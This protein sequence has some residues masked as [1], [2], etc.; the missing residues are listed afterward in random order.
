MNKNLG[1]LKL[2]LCSQDTHGS[3]EAPRDFASSTPAST[4]YCPQGGDPKAG[5]I[6]GSEGSWLQLRG[7]AE[8]TAFPVHSHMVQITDLDPDLWVSDLRAGNSF[9]AA[10]RAG[11]SW[12]LPTPH[13]QTFFPGVFPVKTAPLPAKQIAVLCVSQNHT[14]FYFSSLSFFFGALIYGSLSLCPPKKISRDPPKYIP[15]S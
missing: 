2:R 1:F 6:A 12:Q 3:L 8:P 7:P 15:R 13:E 4:W 5:S 14:A 10:H 9:S 11:T